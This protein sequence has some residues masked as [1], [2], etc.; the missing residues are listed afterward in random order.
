M[1]KIT[2]VCSLVFSITCLNTV[3]YASTPANHL[4]HEST[5]LMSKTSPSTAHTQYLNIEEWTTPNGT[6]VYFVPAR[7]VPIVDL[8]I[9]FNAGST[10]DGKQYGLAAMTSHMLTTGV[11]GLQENKL[12]DK[13]D[14]TGAQISTD[15]DRDMTVIS[16]RSMSMQKY[17]NPAISLLSKITTSPSF[18]DDA[19]KRLQQQSLTSLALEKQSASTIAYKAFIEKLFENNPYASPTSGNEQSV[20]NMT[21]QD[22]KAFYKKYYTAKNAMI[23][24]VGNLSNDEARAISQ[25]ISQGLPEGSMAKAIAMPKK[26][27]NTLTL[28]TPFKSQQTTVLIGAVGVKKGSPLFFPL[29]V[30]NQI[31]G[32]SGLNSLLFNEVRK[33]RG[34]A[35]GAN[36]GFS[37]YANA[38]TFIMSTKTR[39]EK[40]DETIKVMNETLQNFVQNGPTPEQLDAAK[41]Y[42]TGSFPL[43][44]ANNASKLD[45]LNMIA[46]YHL[47][48]GYLDTYTKNI[49]QI[50]GKDIQAAFKEVI[51]KNK[52]LT[53]TVGDASEAPK[54]DPLTDINVKVPSS[55]S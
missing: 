33:E 27:E 34:L 46:F 16:L 28:H 18:P 4:Q 10:R 3:P 14:A 47:P 22:I 19:F 39:S 1:N 9:T 30:G 55:A 42:L 37:T 23:T 41:K 6:P 40:T 48:K 50:T 49:E 38:G 13:I 52:L 36:S 26:T 11:K 53:V 15:S 2:R 7:D 12:L 54:P 44:F 20:K 17:L 45:I 29:L 43:S 32:G 24:I 21:I 5:S 51:A 31:L 8:D 25:R 35:Y